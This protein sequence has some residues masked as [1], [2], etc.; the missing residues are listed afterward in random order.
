MCAI[1][2]TTIVQLNPSP[3]FQ[4][5]HN[6]GVVCV[7]AFALNSLFEKPLHRW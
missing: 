6:A 5:P 3:G 4:D 7:K 2:A 1:R